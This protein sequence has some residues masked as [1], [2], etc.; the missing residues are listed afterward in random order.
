[1]TDHDSSTPRAGRRAAGWAQAF[2][3]LCLLAAL[4]GTA[5]F[6]RLTSVLLILS[7][8]L[9]GVVCRYSKRYM[10]GD[11]GQA[12]FL[13]LLCL[14]GTFVFVLVLCQNLL[15]FALAWF[16]ISISLHHLLQFYRERPGALVAARKKFLISRLG[17]AA[18]AGAVVQA[19]R[20]FG[21]WDFPGMFTAAERLRAAGPDN[22]PASVSVT[23]GLLVFA[24][25]LKSAQFPFHSWLPDTMETPTPV[26]ALMHA[27]IINAGGILII[28]LSPLISLSEAALQVLCAVGGF[29]ALFAS[30]VMLTQASVKRC[31]AFST[32]AQMGFMMLECGLGAFHLALLHLVAH[33]LYK[34]H[35]FLSSGSVVHARAEAPQRSVQPAAVLL[36]I[37][38]ASAISF[39]SPAAWGSAPSDHWTLHGIFTLALAQM[40]WSFWSTTGRAWLVPRGCAA[41]VILSSVYHALDRIAGLVVKPWKAEAGWLGL[42]IL[43]LFLIVALLQTQLPMLARTRWGKHLYVHARNGF[44]FNTL[45]SRITIALWPPSVSPEGI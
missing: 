3:A 18:L 28:R 30:I 16:G 9:F 36:S 11:P 12:R 7:T 32:V 38:A 25:L 34:A 1:M 21:T 15:L 4:A 39:F 14:T 23:C 20:D 22:L 13:F 6:D 8:F 35:A 40:L 27:G 19:Y 10:M 37:L 2:A 43:V 29:T 42:V 31:L 24:A 26:S 17:D 44:Y 5:F 41:A 45:A 33:S